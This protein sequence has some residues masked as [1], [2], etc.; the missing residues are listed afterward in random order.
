[1]RIDIFTIF[2]QMLESPI[3]SGIFKRA[4]ER[5]LAEVHVHNVRDYTHDRHKTVDDYPYG[6]GPGMVFKPGPVFQA[7][8]TVKASLHPDIVSDIPVILLT[9]QG[10]LFSQQMAHQL[11]Q[12]SHLM[13]ICGHY[14]G[15]DERIAEHLATMSISIGDYVL[16]GGELPAMVLVDAIIRLIPGVLG[17]GLSPL[18][19]SH[20]SGLLEYPQYTRPEDF[21]GWVVPDVLLSG[22]HA[23]IAR[24]RREQAIMRTFFRRPDLLEKADLTQEAS[25]YA[26]QLQQ[27][28]KMV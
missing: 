5:G 11:S 27:S 10:N 25:N 4:S 15:V 22:N 3:A 8:E 28:Q 9:P 13:L 12:K 17:S 18:D 24:W 2:P 7:V 26:T 20:T 1:M 6:G 19:D 23:E 14:E 16:S 21:R